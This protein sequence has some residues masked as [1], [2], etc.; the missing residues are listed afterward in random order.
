MKTVSHTD[1]YLK[2]KISPFFSFEVMVS[3]QSF[4]ILYSNP[5]INVQDVNLIFEN[6]GM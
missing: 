5:T 1:F 2:A 4:N 6:M 3:F